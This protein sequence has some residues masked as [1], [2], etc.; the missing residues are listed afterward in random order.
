M[1]RDYLFARSVEEALEMLSRHGGEARL[2]AGGTDLAI[3]CQRGEC[4]SKVMVDVT[5]IPCL[6]RIEEEE[7]WLTVGAAV[8]H[9][10]A[11]SSELV[12]RRGRLLA[13]A[14]R[15]IGGPQIRN[16]GTVVG[17]LVTAL[18]AADAALALVALE[19][20]AEV[21]SAD[22]RRWLPL[23][24]FHLGVGVCRVNP[25]AE[26]ITRVRFRALGPE[27]RSAHERLAQRKVHALPILNVAA[28][29]A[30]RDGRFA[31]MRIALGPVAVKPLRVRESEA[32]LQ[33]R[34][35]SAEAIREAAELA[36]SRC[37]PRD[38]LL[39]GS[40]EYRQALVAVMVRRALERVA[41][42]G[43]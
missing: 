23:A 16:A 43:A 14:C 32:L 8:T 19:G 30:V 31:E 33:G 27:W 13:D 35:P 39:R 18:P 20:E 40:G 10:R 29:G 42:L 24:D 6:E 15:V 17:N 41:G 34:E 7:G 1:W 22:G 37:H 9:A 21:A 36:A 28:V 4:P 3:Q 12:R 26:M 2:I 25:C 11:A 5:R 38:S